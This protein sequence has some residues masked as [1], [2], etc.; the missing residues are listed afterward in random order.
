MV[1]SPS[2][3]LKSVRSSISGK[4]WAVC[5]A[6][7]DR[8]ASWLRTACLRWLS[9]S[10]SRRSS[11]F[12]QANSDWVRSVI[13]AACALAAWTRSSASLIAASLVF[14]ASASA[15]V[16]IR[17]ASLTSSLQPVGGLL[18]VLG[19][20]GQQGGGALGGLL[21]DPAQLGDGLLA[22]DR[23]LLPQSA[24]SRSAVRRSSSVSR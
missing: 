17:A 8:L 4:D 15:S 2:S 20:L 3:A 23:D 22:L 16:R 13:A 24:A 19:G 11:C 9:R 1:R 12:R 10:V 5:C 14:S 18:V 7:A 6:N 21:L